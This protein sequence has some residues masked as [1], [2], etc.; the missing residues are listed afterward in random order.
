MAD[1]IINPTNAF[2]VM[3]EQAKPSDQ[4]ILGMF[5]VSRPEKFGMV[6]FD[7]ADMRVR[8]ID[9]K[10]SETDLT[11]AWGCL[12]WRSDFTEHLYRSVTNGQG[13][14]AEIMNRFILLGS[15]VRAVVLPKGSY[16]DMG[17]Y[18]ELMEIDRQFRRGANGP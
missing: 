4:L 2:Q 14:F 12:V 15:D 1:T 9:D 10:P 5:E 18:D 16:S 3:M 8:Y 13:D 11:L 6:A 17:T 7:E